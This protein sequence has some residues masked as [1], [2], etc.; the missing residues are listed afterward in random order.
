MINIQ[1]G[2]ATNRSSQWPALERRTT[3]QR[4]TMSDCER[5]GCQVSGTRYESE[6]DRAWSIIE[7]LIGTLS[8]KYGCQFGLNRAY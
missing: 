3:D 5:E 2:E 4:D 6:W 7:S 8:Y 1:V